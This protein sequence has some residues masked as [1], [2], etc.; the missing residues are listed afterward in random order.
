MH[1]ISLIGN[2][3]R[4]GGYFA[5]GLATNIEVTAPAWAVASN[6]RI[7][8]AVPVEPTDGDPPAPYAVPVALLQGKRASE[9]RTVRRATLTRDDGVV[10]NVWVDDRGRTA[11]ADAHAMIDFPDTRDLV[12]RV[13]DRSDADG[14]RWAVVD[15]HEL[16]AIAA[17]L[18]DAHALAIG[19]PADSQCEC[20]LAAVTLSADG[21]DDG[22]ALI[23]PRG[24]HV[25]AQERWTCNTKGFMDGTAPT[26]DHAG[27]GAAKSVCTHTDGAGPACG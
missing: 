14:L 13:R 8:V 16:V 9:S 11:R 12:K 3:A 19:V 10:S 15:P 27:T 1:V 5:K 23:M 25:A 17:A 6:G 18:G 4:G 21:N 20:A 7:M 22:F 26:D 24:G 2:V